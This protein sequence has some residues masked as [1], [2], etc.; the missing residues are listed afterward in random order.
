MS[1]SC[2]LSN[3]GESLCLDSLG[4]LAV[5]VPVEVALLLLAFA[6]LALAADHL[7]DSMETLCDHWGLPEEIGGATFMAFGGAVPEI[8]VNSMATMKAIMRGNQESDAALGIGAILGS[9]LLAFLTVPALCSIASVNKVPLLLKRRPLTRDVLFYGASVLVLLHALRT[10][11]SAAHGVL[12]LVVYGV[13]VTVLCYG[14]QVRSWYSQWRLTH[15]AG[16]AAAL[17][18]STTSDGTAEFQSFREFRRKASDQKS[19]VFRDKYDE[20]LALPLMET[21][22]TPS[23]ADTARTT[24]VLQNIQTDLAAVLWPLKR[25]VDVTCPDCRIYQPREN[26]YAVTFLA[27]FAWVS[28]AS[29]VVGCVVDRWVALLQ[30]PSSSGFFGLALVA[31]GAEVPDAINALTATYRGYGSMAAASC[32]GSQIINI[33]VGLG[34]PWALTLFASGVVPVSSGSA[35]FL[36]TVA[37]INAAVATVLAC[38]LVWQGRA[39]EASQYCIIDRARGMAALQCYLAVI[40]L[41]GVLTFAGTFKG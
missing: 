6:T 37:C 5:E 10:S 34:L 9:G 33:C 32:L 14:D 22:S 1:E 29:F 15:R 2:T 3:F 35:V 40:L 38:W 4:S 18:P 19:S 21:G 26:L 17:E 16:V 7:C 36:K 27:S 39:P 30:N 8:T 31:L 11:I 28:L 41:L 23:P 12:L 24:P 25:V 13:Y 20:E